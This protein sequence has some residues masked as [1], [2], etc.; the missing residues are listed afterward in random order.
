MKA[1]D[2]TGSDADLQCRSS[3]Q[4]RNDVKG[5]SIKLRQH[6]RL[7]EFLTNLSH[8]AAANGHQVKLVGRSASNLTDADADAV[9]FGLRV[10]HCVA[11]LDESPQMIE[12]ARLHRA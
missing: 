4:L 5:C 3:F 2:E 1:H 7:T 10:L 9:T 8:R 12:Y 11:M 6:D